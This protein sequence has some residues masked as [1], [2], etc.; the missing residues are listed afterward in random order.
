MTN[1]TRGPMQPPT[2][3]EEMIPV[4][5]MIGRPGDNERFDRENRAVTIRIDRL[6]EVVTLPV[7]DADRALRFYVEEVGFA[8][9][10]DYARTDAFRV[11]Q[12]TPPSS[13]CSIQLGTGLTDAP[14]GSVRN[15]H[16]DRHRPPDHP[17]GAARARCAGQR[18]PGLN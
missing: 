12:L 15:S 6:V 11:A 4:R 7:S 18:D 3:F 5:P 17:G 14:A 9:D 10:I 8:L 13:S 1:L 16:L 2:R